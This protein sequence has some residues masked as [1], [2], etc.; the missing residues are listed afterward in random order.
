MKTLFK[1]AVVEYLNNRYHFYS[2]IVS[3]MV[4]IT[5]VYIEGFDYVI[6]YP[7]VSGFYQ[8]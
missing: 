8:F 7:Q 5:K 1:I 4:I 3:N 2:P 6:N